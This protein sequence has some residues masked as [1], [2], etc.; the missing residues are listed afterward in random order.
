MIGLRVRRWN[1]SAGCAWLFVAALCLAIV[2][3]ATA[4][5]LPDPAKPGPYPVGVTTMTLVDHSRTD[6][7]TNGPR[8]LLT[9]IWYPA[10]DEARS[11]PKNK[12]SDFLMRGQAPVYR[13]ALEFA[14]NA[15]AANIDEQFQNE[16]I[17]D[18]PVRDGK[19]PLIVFSH[20]NRSIRMQS[21]FWCDHM[22]SHGYIV[23]AADHTGNAAVT[24]VDG[25]LVMFKEEDI[26]QAQVDRPQ[27]VSFLI[28]SMHRLSRG[29][30]SRF[31]GRVDMERVGAAGHSFG[32]YTVTRSIEIDPRIKAIAPMAS[33]LDPERENFKT[34][35]MMIVATEDATLGLERNENIRNYF[36]ASQGPRYLIEILDAGHFSFS[37]MFQFKPN[38]GDGVG[39]G[40]RITKPGEP[41][42]YLDMQTTYDIVNSYSTA[43]FGVFLQD[44]EGYRDYL[45]A[46]HFAELV[47]HDYGQPGK[48]PVAVGAGA[49]N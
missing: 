39:K 17:R 31:A 22:A 10:V 34:P 49:G 45:K 23:V 32:G 26:E 24:I 29:E 38:I 2:P 8:S 11:L 4:D 19:F 28:D 41:I 37:D 27:D 21:T 35:V 30:D 44:R 36:A 43:F 14:F 25:K 18:A 12:Y 6:T 33:T 42:D 40:E 5:D 20:G 47:S 7:R 3:V 46:N 16:A 48:A 13:A 15:K 9:E 1:L